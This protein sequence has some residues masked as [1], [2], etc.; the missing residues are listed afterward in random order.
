MATGSSHR[1]VWVLLPIVPLSPTCTWVPAV[2]ECRRHSYLEASAPLLPCLE[3]L[4]SDVHPCVHLPV[5]KLLVHRATLQTFTPLP[6][7]QHSYLPQLLHGTNHR[8]SFCP[9][10]T[11]IHTPSDMGCLLCILLYPGTENTQKV[12]N[13]CR[14]NGHNTSNDKTRNL[15]PQNTIYTP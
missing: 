11:R 1:L 14:V 4:S 5:P 6:T 2:L 12:L 3:S 10:S 15:S 9:L 8:N 7:L 13:K